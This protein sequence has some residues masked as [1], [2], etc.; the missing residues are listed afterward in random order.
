MCR[1]P[2]NF[3]AHPPTSPPPKPPAA[4]GIQ[5]KAAPNLKPPAKPARPLGIAPR[6]STALGKPPQPSSKT[7]QPPVA[8]KP[9]P[10]KPAVAST[11]P[12][13]P[14]EPSVGGLADAFAQR[15][16]EP[17]TSDVSAAIEVLSAGA[18]EEWYVGINGVPLGPVRLSTLRQKAQQGAIDENSLVWRA[19]FEEW[20]PLRTFPELL[21]LVREGQESGSRASLLP[22]VP[23]PSVPARTAFSPGAFGHMAAPTH[24]SAP[25]TVSESAAPSDPDLD[26][27]TIIASGV[28]PSGVA[29][30]TTDPFASTQPAPEPSASPSVPAAARK[31]FVDD[32]TLGVRKQVRMHPA[33]YVLIAI[34]FGFGATGAIVFFT[35]DREPAPPPTIQVVTVTAP[36]TAPSELDASAAASVAMNT[37]SLPTEVKGGSVPRA[38]S[39]SKTPNGK[40]PSKTDETT[41]VPR[42]GLG[43]SPLVDGPSV[44]GPRSEGGGNLPQQLDQ[45]DIE[46]VVNAHRSSVKRGCWEPALAGRSPNAPK[47]AKVTVLISIGPSGQVTQA[48]ASGGDGFPGLSSCI[49]SKVRAWKFPPSGGTS[50]ANVPF[51]FFSQ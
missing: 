20:L 25:P 44:G 8:A 45:S 9:E 33:A 16:R 1:R 40:E 31:S 7:P 26:S 23:Q 30:L 42:L 15:V 32:L 10:P 21:V 29:I 22:A 4:S 38:G 50:Q 14:S 3:R 12:E 41:G 24:S 2:P 17:Q 46:R 5:K 48:S 49:V 36:P 11:A 39:E 37:D 28:Q 6:P 43:P 13:V 19:G 51:A 18:G 34:A 35:N 27:P 47:S